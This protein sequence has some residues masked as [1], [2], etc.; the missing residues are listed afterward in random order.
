MSHDK[1]YARRIEIILRDSEI[2][3]GN[4]EILKKYYSHGKIQQITIGSQSARLGFLRLLAIF[5]KKD[6]KDVTKEDI[7]KY[8]SS[9][10]ELG[11][12]TWSSMGA[13]IK[14]FFRWLYN[15]D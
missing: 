5:V 9:K 13:T 6:F 10:G 8:F 11:S 3:K 12:K 4:L 7:E 2:G 14:S 15:L 1:Y